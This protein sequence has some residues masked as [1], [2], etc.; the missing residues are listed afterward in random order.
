MKILR[1]LVIAG[2]SSIMFFISQPKGITQ[3]NIPLT[4]DEIEEINE[5]IPPYKKI[6]IG[7]LVELL[8]TNN[9]SQEFLNSM[10]LQMENQFQQMITNGIG[11]N[12][13]YEEQQLMQ[14]SFTRVITRINQLMQER[15][16]FQ[17][18][19]SE[20]SIYLYNTYY[21]ESELEDIIAFYETQTGKKVLDIMPQITEESI[22]LYSSIM[23]PTIIEIQTQVL[24][25]EF[26]FLEE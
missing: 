9:Q 16:D 4:L 3:D 10:I 14:E 24:E 15:I 6:L 22:N 7:T 17:Y 8:F 11:E 25:E 21:T 2:L 13:S 19:E 26:S 18:L 23:L 12:L 5:N 20:I 1:N